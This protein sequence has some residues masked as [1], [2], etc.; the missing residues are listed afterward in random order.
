MADEV[1][2]QGPNSFGPIPPGDFR[3][4]SYEESVIISVDWAVD[5]VLH[6]TNRPVIAGGYSQ[7]GEAA[8]RFR[9]EF[10]PGKRLEHLR[11]NWVCGYVF[12][13]P[14]R[15]L[16]STYY[17]GPPTPWEGIAQSRLPQMGNDWCELI[18]PGD[19]YGTCMRGLGGEIERDVYTMC[20]QMEM[21]SGG[22]EFC[23]T[24]VAN[25][26]EVAKNLD[27]D[28]YDDLKAGAERYG[29][30]LSGATMAPPEQIEEVS[31]GVL[32]VKGIVWAIA[33]A[34][35]ALIFFCSPPFPT[36]PHCEYHVRE[37]WPGMTYV[38]LAIQHVHDW[39]NQ[40]AAR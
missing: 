21:H 30:D 3:A 11:Q 25:L 27:G 2:V 15:H 20:T 18:D 36:A 16:E 12:G 40:Y 28:A 38:G 19:M 31:R 7:G 17:G 33:A 13:N 24:L 9:M 37:V 10:E 35:D 32:S 23:I 39:A 14:S 26:I 5:W 6:N 8:S 22:V 29:V 1:A 34:V 4:P